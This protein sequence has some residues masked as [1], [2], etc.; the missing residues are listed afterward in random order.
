MFPVIYPSTSLLVGARVIIADEPI[1]RLITVI[2]SPNGSSYKRKYKA[3]RRRIRKSLRDIFIGPVC[4]FFTWLSCTAAV[5]GEC[6][7]DVMKSC[8][9]ADYLSR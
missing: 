8:N 5:P 3:E 6:A 9:L 7:V 4:R 1:K 2:P